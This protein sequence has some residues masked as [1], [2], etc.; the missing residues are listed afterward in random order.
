MQ[1][2]GIK[3]PSNVNKLKTMSELGAAQQALLQ[4]IASGAVTAAEW[5]PIQK[6]LNALQ[7]KWQKQA[8][9]ACTPADFEVLK[10][11]FGPDKR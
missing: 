6:E 4:D 11:I 7:K 1:I 2:L 3:R 8:H 9:E 5:R 10:S